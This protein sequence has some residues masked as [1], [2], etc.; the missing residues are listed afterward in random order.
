MPIISGR[1]LLDNAVV[2]NAQGRRWGAS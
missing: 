1:G 2:A